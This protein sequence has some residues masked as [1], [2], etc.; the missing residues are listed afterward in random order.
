[1]R[2][3]SLFVRLALAASGALCVL[4]IVSASTSTPD[5]APAARPAA[6]AR[7]ASPKPVPSATLRGPSV[8]QQPTNFVGDDTCVTCH[9]QK[10][11]GT[12]HGRSFNERTPAA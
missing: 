2:S 8:A 5:P 11:D 12:A 10:L 4:A 3:T 1:M 7:P 9:E 6:V